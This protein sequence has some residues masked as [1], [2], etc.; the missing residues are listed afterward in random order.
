MKDLNR[1]LA[2]EEIQMPSEYIKRC[3]TSCI[4]T[5]LK[6]QTMSYHYTSIKIDKIKTLTTPNADMDMEQ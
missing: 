2:K 5:E 4:I 1:Y 3:C 6:I